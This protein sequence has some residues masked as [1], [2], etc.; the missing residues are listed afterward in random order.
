[1]S[2]SDNPWKDAVVSI[3]DFDMENGILIGSG[4]MA[5]VMSA[6][7]TGTAVPSA[8]GTRVAIKSLDKG[9]ILGN[10][11]ALDRLHNEK[12]ALNEMQGCR[13]V[14][15]IFTTLQSDTFVHFVM[16]YAEAGDLMQ[17][18]RRI[19]AFPIAV[20]RAIAA[21]I[22]LT[23]EYQHA[24][25]IV[26]RDL[27]PENVC[28]VLPNYRA[29]LID[30]EHVDFTDSEPIGNSGK[31]LPD[32]DPREDDSDEE[33]KYTSEE[34]HAIRRKSSAFCGTVTTVSPEML[35][36]CQWSYASDLWALGVVV[37]TMVCG[38]EPFG[39]C[40]D[41]MMS[42]M[43]NVISN[44]YKP[45][46]DTVPASAVDLIRSLLVLDPAQR[47]GTAAMGGWAALRA[48]AFFEGVNW[49]TVYDD[50]VPFDEGKEPSLSAAYVH[51]LHENGDTDFTAE[52]LQEIFA[53]E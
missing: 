30:Y 18:V 3:D 38:T 52:R 48:H 15:R 47:L 7:Y 24:R 2:A 31:P 10:Q 9:R 35:G 17:H 23:L 20:S 29:V 44:N 50:K 51:E 53:K 12:K 46:P 13:G 6:V 33:V 1:M 26:H 42:T 14:P 19:G 5:V 28:F 37:Y 39:G 40:L 43:R 36:S 22:V 34:V 8:T 25:K 45:I 11:G 16:E 21:Q 41:P 4:A 49:S 27:K 32:S